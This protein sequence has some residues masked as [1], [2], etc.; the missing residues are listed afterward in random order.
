MLKEYLPEERHQIRLHDLLM[1][2]FNRALD[3]LND[4][5]FPVHAGD[6]KDFAR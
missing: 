4:L 1:G 5:Q 6:L 3:R 2:E